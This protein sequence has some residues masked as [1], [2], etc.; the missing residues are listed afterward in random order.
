MARKMNQLL[1]PQ[2][3]FHDS[4]SRLTK[5]SSLQE[6]SATHLNG[7]TRRTHS[8]S[9]CLIE[10]E[11]NVETHETTPDRSITKS[12]SA[13]R[14]SSRS[15][16][17]SEIGTN[18][19]ALSLSKSLDLAETKKDPRQ[20]NE[21]SKQRSRKSHQ[22]D[23]PNSSDGDAKP[24][25]RS[26]STDSRR[27]REALLNK[28]RFQAGISADM[29]RVPSSIDCSSN[30]SHNM[31][32]GSSSNMV[33][34]AYMD[35]KLVTPKK[36][37]TKEELY[38]DKDRAAAVVLGTRDI[39]VSLQ[40]K[41]KREKHREKP[42]ES[43][44]DIMLLQGEKEMQ[45]NNPQSAIVFFNK[46]L[47]IQPESIR[48]LL[49]RSKCSL[50][51]SDYHS[52]KDDAEAALQRD[53]NSFIALY[54]KA[55][56]LYGIGEFEFSLV[57]YHRAN[58]FR[59]GTEKYR[60]GIQ[61]AEEAITKLTGFK[62]AI[63]LE[64]V[65]KHLDNL[66]DFQ[67]LK[68]STK[69][70]KRVVKS[71]LGSLYSDQV[72]LKNLA[73]TMG[74][75]N[76]NSIICEHAKEALMYLKQRKEFW[77]KQKAIKSNVSTKLKRKDSPTKSETNYADYR[78]FCLVNKSKKSVKEIMDM[79]LQVD[80]DLNR[81]CRNCLIKCENLLRLLKDYSVEELEKKNE[82]VSMLY[83]NIGIVKLE[84]EDYEGAL[85][86]HK[87]DLKMAEKF[88]LEDAKSRA[89]D[90]IGRTHAL[91]GNFE[92]AINAWKVKLPLCKDPIEKSWLHHEIGRCYLELGELEDASEFGK[93][94]LRFAES[95]SDLM[96]QLNASVMLA[97]IKVQKAN[98][99]EAISI[100][101]QA[102]ILAENLGNK[103]AMKAIGQVLKRLQRRSTSV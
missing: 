31:T 68:T 32:G 7:R 88:H 55:E 73:K 99:I 30:S 54:Q 21:G 3:S 66:E 2:E 80:R 18:K 70:K 78:P 14:H 29:V 43:N 13:S 67:E 34:S 16:V 23:L 100:F 85:K 26:I 50:I 48:G 44:C 25:S 83:S 79:L 20:N 77:L 61:K 87:L 92:E 27:A 63:D 35:E 57:F 86:Y 53:E 51:L 71:L 93:K 94:S 102:Q 103:K 72:Y 41:I 52:A 62:S 42:H 97:Q 90:N 76:D 74:Q 19:R 17:T 8:M 98:Y 11:N 65:E 24:R 91:F 60:V 15:S 81:N 56:A 22:L 101:H 49:A 38:T 46:A 59:P 10:V 89:L 12:K 58:R 6:K 96:W 45:K 82:I 39:K 1:V 64:R 28:G 40:N 5:R 37:L 84:F 33:D 36:F 69:A 47:T 95:A 9:H 75:A 4:K